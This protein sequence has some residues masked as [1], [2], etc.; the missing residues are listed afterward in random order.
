ML[1]DGISRTSGIGATK[2]TTGKDY[3]PN[4]YGSESRS[5]GTPNVEYGDSG[6]YSRYFSLDAWWNKQIS[7][8]P[9]S[10]RNTFPFLISPKASKS[11]KG[12]GNNH[13]TVKPLALMSYLVTLGS[14]PND[15]VVD[16]YCGSGTTGIA[17]QLLSRHFIGIDNDEPSC[18]IA[19]ARLNSLLSLC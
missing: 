6:S 1:N 18:K 3:Q 19:R 11:E 15:T 2:Q 9:E 16:P 5:I 7:Q 12:K 4:A 8:L 10:V 17:C 13:P 14:R